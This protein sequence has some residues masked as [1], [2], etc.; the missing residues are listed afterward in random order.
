MHRMSSSSDSCTFFH[1]TP[2]QPPPL[3]PAP[4]WRAA[5]LII[6]SRGCNVGGC[7]VRGCNVGGCNVG[8]CNVHFPP[9]LLTIRGENADKETVTCAYACL[10]H[11][12]RAMY[13]EVLTSLVTN[14]SKS[15]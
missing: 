3:H 2:L 6:Y 1:P 9:Q 4:D 13:D 11:K 12:D 10:T 8:G 5:L 7:N 14:M 15:K